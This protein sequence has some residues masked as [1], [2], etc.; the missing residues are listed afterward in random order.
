MSILIPYRRDLNEKRHYRL[1][2]TF[3]KDEKRPIKA[4]ILII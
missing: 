3:H 2:E 4:N 1:K